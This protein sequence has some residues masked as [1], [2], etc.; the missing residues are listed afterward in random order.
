[1]TSTGHKRDIK[2]IV[3]VYSDNNISHIICKCNNKYYA[4]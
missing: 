1:M 2:Q 3:F 4:K